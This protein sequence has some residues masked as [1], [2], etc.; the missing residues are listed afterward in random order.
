MEKNTYIITVKNGSD[1]IKKKVVYGSS[2][3]LSYKPRR[4]YDLPDGIL[5]ERGSVANSHINTLQIRL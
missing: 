3:V 2:V 5:T 1:C 4:G